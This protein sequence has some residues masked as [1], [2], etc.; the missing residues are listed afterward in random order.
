MK[1]LTFCF[2][3]AAACGDNLRPAVDVDAGFDLSDVDLPEKPPA[4]EPPGE[5][6]DSGT[7]IPD[8]GIDAPVT[9]DAGPVCVDS[10]IELNGQE[11]KCQHDMDLPPKEP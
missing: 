7:P 3:I 10:H 6:P 2:L 5:V 1:Q 9:P 11:H 8:A 4:Q